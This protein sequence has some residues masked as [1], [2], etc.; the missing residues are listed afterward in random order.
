M[1]RGRRL[2]LPRFNA[3]ARVLDRAVRIEEGAREVGDRLAAPTH[4]HAGTFGHDRDAVGFKVFRLR[5]GNELFFILRRH[6]DGHALLRFGDRKL[7]AV[8]TFVLLA[9]GVEVD[10]KAVGQLADGD[11]H[12]ARAKVVAALDEAR[13]LAVAEQALDLALLGRVALLD[14]AR[15]GGQRL[16]VVALR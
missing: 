4:D 15:H 11:G 16:Q 12:A 5:R 3:D 14:L 9:H 7:S 8:E 2:F 10:C 13:D 6:D 1:R